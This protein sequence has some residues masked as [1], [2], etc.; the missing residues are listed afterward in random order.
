MSVISLRWE[1]EGWGGGI[2]EYER[3][4]NFDL[5]SVTWCVFC[6]SSDH[7]VLGVT[8]TSVSSLTILTQEVM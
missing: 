4:G 6:E 1:G 2:N 8:V 5:D 7:L 3:A